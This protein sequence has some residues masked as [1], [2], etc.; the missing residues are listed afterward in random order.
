M[1]PG[2]E[3][4]ALLNQSAMAT[5]E[6]DSFRYAWN[7]FSRL[8]VSE[9]KGRQ[10]YCFR[11]HDEPPERVKK[12]LVKPIFKILGKGNEKGGRLEAQNS[13]GARILQLD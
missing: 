6:R 4:D 3:R 2:S 9:T 13:I 1:E 5:G 10:G 7:H 8:G 12:K 11:F